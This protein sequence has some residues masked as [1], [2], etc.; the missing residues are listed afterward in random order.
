MKR[1][2]LIAMLSALLSTVAYADD[3]VVWENDLPK[4]LMQA[5]RTGEQETLSSTYSTELGRQIACYSAIEPAKVDPYDRWFNRLASRRRREGRRQYGG[6]CLAAMAVPV[7]FPC[8]RKRSIGER[9]LSGRGFVYR[10]A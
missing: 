6:G 5:E 9:S 1:L 8:L 4:A 10:L 7:V 3:G 2:A